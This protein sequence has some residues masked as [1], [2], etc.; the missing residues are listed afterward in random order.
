MPKPEALLLAG[1]YDGAAAQFEATGDY[2]DSAQR[3]PMTHYVHAEAQLASNDLA[4]AAICFYKAGNYQDAK[5]R[6]FD[7][8]NQIAVRESVSAG[9]SHAIGLKASGSVVAVGRNDEGQCGVSGWSDIV[10]VS[11]GY[12]HTVG[13]KADGTIVAT[14]YTGYDNFY[15]GQCDVSGWSDIVAVSAG[16]LQR[17]GR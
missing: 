15:D 4:G 1:D 10:A 16:Y 6:S 3:I 7:L 2:E 12:E 9:A 8:W 11:A 13:L 5:A 14:E 17:L